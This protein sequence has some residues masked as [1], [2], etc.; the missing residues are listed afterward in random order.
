MNIALLTDVIPQPAQL[1]ELRESM[2][3]SQHEL[4]TALG[5]SPLKAGRIVRQWENGWEGHMPFAPT[6]TAWAAF[7]YLATLAAIYQS[8]EEGEDTKASVR[9]FLPVVLT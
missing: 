4:G 8:D 9:R 3:L 6:P 7:R 5:F 1:L 2:G